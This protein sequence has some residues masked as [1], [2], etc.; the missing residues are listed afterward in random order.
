MELVTILL[1]LLLSTNSLEN[2]NGSATS[3]NTDTTST[4]F[5][6]YDDIQP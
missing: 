4:E 1:S 2:T 5:I 6:I 3:G